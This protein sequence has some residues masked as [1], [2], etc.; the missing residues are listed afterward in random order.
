[1]MIWGHKKAGIQM[2]P[3]SRK[4]AWIQEK[5][6]ASQRRR[7]RQY[8]LRLLIIITLRHYDYGKSS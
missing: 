6:Y 1:M 2:E 3:R 8:A 7:E 4:D 5:G